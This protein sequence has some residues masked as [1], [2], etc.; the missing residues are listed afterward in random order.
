MENIGTGSLGVVATM[1][2][3]QAKM[4]LSQRVRRVASIILGLCPSMKNR[5]HYAGG[6]L[7]ILS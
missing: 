2:T 7:F 6:L 5:R 4:W 1:L 3:R